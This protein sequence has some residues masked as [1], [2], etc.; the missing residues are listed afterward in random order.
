MPGGEL[1][2]E[3]AE[4]TTPAAGHTR[5][6]YP[7]AGDKWRTP[8]SNSAHTRAPGMNRIE[9]WHDPAVTS[10][11]EGHQ[12]ARTNR[13]DP[14]VPRLGRGRFRS[15]PPT[16]TSWES[17]PRPC[18]RRRGRCGRPSS[19]CAFEFS[20]TPII[21]TLA[22]V[23]LR[24]GRSRLRRCAGDRHLLGDHQPSCARRA[25]TASAMVAPAAAYRGRLPVR[26]LRCSYRAALV[27]VIA[28]AVCQSGVSG[29]RARTPAAHPR[30]TAGRWRAPSARSD[31]GAKRHLYRAC[32]LAAHAASASRATASPSR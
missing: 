14:F 18:A 12:H 30:C 20:Q 26:F 29:A 22:P 3:P 31:R 1:S 16:F 27:A 5:A 32:W 25:S 13:W 2:A 4:S 8:S 15:R 6:R 19:A 9:T 28:S 11:C 17:A 24:E 7:R 10:P 23:F 21:G